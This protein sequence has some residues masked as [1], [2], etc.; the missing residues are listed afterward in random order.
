MMVSPNSYINSHK[1]DAMEDLLKE[2]KKLVDELELLEK[3]AFDKG[4]KDKAWDIQPG[5]DVRYKVT[6]E[7]LAELCRLIG[8]RY[9]EDTGSEDPIEEP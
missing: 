3:V 5:P 2:K 8:R 4:H 7:Y 6:L 9:S 1:N